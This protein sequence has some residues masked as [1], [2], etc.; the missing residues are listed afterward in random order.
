MNRALTKRLHPD[1][2]K[3]DRLKES[4]S[5]AVFALLIAAYW[6]V[7]KWQEWTLIPVWV[8]L[9][10][11]LPSLIIFT[12]LVPK[13]HFERFR[14]ELFQEELE[15]QSGLIFIS[16]V[17]VPMVKVQH[18]EMESGPILRKFGLAK[19]LIVTA[20]T[21]HKISGLKL[22]DAERLKQRIGVLARVDEKDE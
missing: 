2:L 4:I 21:T 3:A 1:Y 16:N 14:Y 11:L 5:N 18:V 17:L 22:E 13:V 8:C 20:A 19:V 12:W 7:A 6:I 15:I 9:A 10:L